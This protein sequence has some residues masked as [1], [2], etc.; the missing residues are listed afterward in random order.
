MNE[1]TAFKSVRAMDWRRS[2]RRPRLTLTTTNASRRFAAARPSDFERV[3]IWGHVHFRG[4]HRPQLVQIFRGSTPIKY[5]R[6]AYK[7]RNLIERCVTQLRQFR[8]IA[9]RY[10]KTARAYNSM[11]SI[12]AASFWIKTVN[13]A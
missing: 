7:R 3:R 10:E 6:E 5:D 12:A 1:F 11:L 8:R 9:T 4:L 2:R 13:T